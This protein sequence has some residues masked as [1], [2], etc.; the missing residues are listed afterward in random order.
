M[1]PGGRSPSNAT[2]CPP[3]TAGLEK[4]HRR[5]QVNQALWRRI[6]RFAGVLYVRPILCE[7]P[8]STRKGPGNDLQGA[9]E[10][11]CAVP[12]ADHERGGKRG[13]LRFSRRA[14]TTLL[15]QGARAQEG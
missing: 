3:P 6:G 12:S 15:L 10:R 8:A 1:M 14:K 13:A 7:S 4:H 5:E 2:A 9:P 11:P